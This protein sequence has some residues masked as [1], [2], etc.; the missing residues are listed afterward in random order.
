[1]PRSWCTGLGNDRPFKTTLATATLASDHNWTV[2]WIGTTLGVVLADGLAIGAGILL[3]QR[4]PEQL[5]HVLAGLLFLLFGLWM[6]F[7]SAL[8]LRSVAI[9][10]TAAV[11]LAAAT[12]TTAQTLSRRRTVA[13][14]PARSPDIA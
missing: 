1:M 11:A 10:V 9:A 14:M 12:V 7:D 3:N 4:L 5:L 6:L 13:A 2:V 8:G